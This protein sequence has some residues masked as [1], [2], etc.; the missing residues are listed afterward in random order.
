MKTK[1]FVISIELKDNSNIRNNELLTYILV[2]VRMWGGQGEPGNDPFFDEIYA[3][4]KRV[5]VK[6]L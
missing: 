2:A 4:Q 1:R 3:H 6:P 5:T